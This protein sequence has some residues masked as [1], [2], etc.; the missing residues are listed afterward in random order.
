M[1]VPFNRPP[2][3]GKELDY[4][5]QV[6]EERYLQSGGSFTR[7][8]RAALEGMTGCGRALLTHSCTAALEMSALLCRLAPGD[9][10]IMPS[11]TFVS[12]AS[13]VALRGATPVF[14]D[15]RPDTLNLD[16]TLVEGAITAKTKAIFAVHYAGVGCEPAKLRAIADARGLLLVED[17]AQG[18]SA[19]FEGRPLGSFGHLAAISFHATKN[20]VA[21][22]AG[23]LLI[24]D[25]ELVERAEIILEKGTNRRQFQRRQIDKYT[26][27]GLGS[28]Y[29]AG[30]L[31]AAFLRAQLECAETVTKERLELWNTYHE[32]L[33]AQEAAERL[34]RPVIPE[35]CAHNGHIYYVI[36]P[37]AEARD[38]ALRGFLEA[39]VEAQFHYVPLHSSPAGRALGRPQGDLAVTA[40]LAARLLRLPLWFGMGDETAKVLEALE[41][42]LGSHTKS[43]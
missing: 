5:R 37:T 34:R 17:A 1:A 18:L 4:L 27:V 23:A 8:C 3:V 26:W 33:A 19:S 21:G 42:V 6:L 22:E 35:G 13:A 12:T 29:A 28:S 36:L 43:R 2:V 41:T 10:V 9:E 38:D 7:A 39:G 11:F 40:D 20:V 15:I 16:E 30:E 25:P 32:A 14:V 24:N 31:V